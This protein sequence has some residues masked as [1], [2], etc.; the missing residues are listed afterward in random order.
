MISFESRSSGR[1][2]MS[3]TDGYSQTA[4]TLDEKTAMELL[5]QFIIVCN[6]A[7]NKNIKLETE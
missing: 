1:I 4:S 3:V 6:I 7:F 2:E 5:D